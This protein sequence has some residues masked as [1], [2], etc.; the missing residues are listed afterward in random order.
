MSQEEICGTT[1]VQVSSL[2]LASLINDFL[3]G[4]SM[5]SIS[6]TIPMTEIAKRMFVDEYEGI[7]KDIRGNLRYDIGY[8][9]VNQTDEKMVHGMFFLK[10]LTKCLKTQGICGY[11]NTGESSLCSLPMVVG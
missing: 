8:T 4:S 6:D 2:H 10:H 1:Y 5:R 9:A 3:P 7:G 11:E